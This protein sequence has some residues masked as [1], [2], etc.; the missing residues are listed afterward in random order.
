MRVGLVLEGGAMRGMFTAGVLDVF[1]DNNIKIDG[2]IGTSAGALFGPN[3]YSKQRGRVIRYNKRFCQYK[4]YVSIRNLI[5]TG[6]IISKKYAFYKMNEEL[7]RFDEKEF[8]R[9]NK[10]FW[11]VAT[12]V[13]TGLP[14]YLKITKP[15]SE[16]EILRA[17]SAIPLVSRMV[18]IDG[19]KY[20]DGGI[21]DSIPIEAIMR[22][23]YDKIIIILTQPIDFSKPPLD[24]KM[25][26]KIRRKYWRYPRLIDAM[27]N[28]YN[29]YNKSLELVKKLE[30][31]HKAFVI[32]PKEKINIKL[33][34][35][36]PEVLQKVYEQGVNMATEVIEDL[37]KYL[38]NDKKQVD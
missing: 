20:L 5:L 6:N 13:K 21:G 26:R 32:R 33:I 8:K 35:R 19:K 18:K 2:I 22:K 14:E 9:N 12:N 38:K 27:K 31:D 37:K 29:N 15:L 36:N 11:A 30:K 7:D 1:L 17:S 24:K 28:R 4:R 23:G 3:Y 10:G 25:I 34:E 16:M